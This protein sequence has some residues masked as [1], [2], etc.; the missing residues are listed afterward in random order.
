MVTLQV[1][2][3]SDKRQKALSETEGAVVKKAEPIPYREAIGSLL[4]LANGSRPDIAYAVNQLS[5]RQSNP[6]HQDFE[7]V[8]C[9]FRY[10]KGTTDFGLAYQSKDDFVESYSDASHQDCPDSRHSTTGF[11]IKVFGD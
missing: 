6:T 10:L 11:T 7:Y 2:R 5:R 1:K 4:Y 3:N 8:K 9:V